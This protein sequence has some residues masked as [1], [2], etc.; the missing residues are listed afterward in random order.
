MPVAVVAGAVANKAESGGEAW[1]RLSYLAGLR[2]LGW[3]VDF[4]E[5]IGPE[6]CDE[7]AIAYFDAVLAGHGGARTSMLVGPGGERL[8]GGAAEPE[9]LAADADLLLNISGNLTAPALLRRFRR[10]AFVDIDPGF[11]QIW[12]AGGELEIPPHDLHFTIA[13]NIGQAG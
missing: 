4:I 9:E 13:G 10:T 8:H 5:Q 3:T 6:A 12:H 1:V 7:R 11:T 2:R